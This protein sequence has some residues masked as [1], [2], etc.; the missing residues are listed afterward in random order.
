MVTFWCIC[1]VYWVGQLQCLG[2]LRDRLLIAI[3]RQCKWRHIQPNERF[4]RCIGFRLMA[5]GK[6]SCGKICFYYQNGLYIP[7][8]CLWTPSRYI[9][10]AKKKWIK[11]FHLD[12][13]PPL[14]EKWLNSSRK[15]SSKSLDLDQTPSLWK[16]SKLKRKKFHKKFGFGLDPPPL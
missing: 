1:P 13:P 15:S 9:F 11:G 4:S 6:P 3:S 7:P 2:H 16:M 12:H 5:L 10:Q 14:F 8:L